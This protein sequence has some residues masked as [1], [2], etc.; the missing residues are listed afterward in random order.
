M[1]LGEV[2]RG[3]S[4]WCHSPLPGALLATV[5]AV[6]ARFA[7]M[8]IGQRT[9]AALAAKRSAGIKLGRPVEIPSEIRGRIRAMRASGA[10]LAAI[11]AAL[12]AEGIPT[13]RGGSRWQIATIE[14]VLKPRQGT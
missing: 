8:L 12:T 2:E 7:R 6:F 10:T 14:R 5:L 13:A 11:V 4:R 3:R 1:K 9:R